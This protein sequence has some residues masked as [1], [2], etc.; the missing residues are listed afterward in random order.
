MAYTSVKISADSSSYQS[1]MKSAASQMKVLSAEYT[2]AA[3]KAKLFGSETDSL[4]AK[5]ESLTQKI[6]V[7]KNIVQL[8]SEQQEKL[9]KKLSDQKTKQEELKTKIDAAKEAYEKSTAET[10]KNSEQSKA[11]KD[12]LDKLEKEFTANETAIGKTETALANQTVKTEKSKTALMNMEAELKNVND[13]LKDNKLE[14]FATACD[15]AGTKMESFG[16][17][18]SVVSA[19][20]AGI[21]AASIKAFTELDEGYDTIVTKTGATGEA[22]E[23][24]TKSADNV[25]GTMPEDMS[26]VGE[27]I[28][29]VNTR[30]HTTGTELEKTS[31][32]FIQFAT[33]NGTNVTQSVDQ[34]DKIMKAWNVDASQTG[35]LL[36][37]LT[38]K[39]QETGISVDTLE[40]NVLDNN[41]AFKEMG[42][43]LPQAIN[44]MAQ[45][46][47]NGVDSTQAMAGLKKALQNAT[48]EGKSMDEALSETIG[49]IKNAK[50]ETEAMQIATELFGK[51]G[52]AEMTKAIRENRIDL[53][54]LS[55]SME[56]YGTTVEDTYNGTLD[57][58][59]NAKVAMNNAK[60]ALSTLASTAQTSAAPMIEKLTGKIQELTKWFTSLSPAQ[61]E[62]ILKV[63]LVVAAI[64]PLSIGFGKVAKGISDTVTTGQKFV[65][66]AAKI[67]AKITAKTAATAAGT[68]ADTAEFEYTSDYAGTMYYLVQDADQPEPSADA[69]LGGTKLA[70]GTDEAL[71]DLTGLNGNSAKKLYYITASSTAAGKDHTTAGKSGEMS[72]V[73]SANIPAYTAPSM[74]LTDTAAVRESKSTGTVTFTAPVAG[75]YHY[76]VRDVSELICDHTEVLAGTEAVMTVGENQIALTGLTDNAAKSVFLYAQGADGSNSAVTRI[77]LPAY[78][79]ATPSVTAP[80][81]NTLT[82]NGNAQPL[83]TAGSTSGGR[84]EYRLGNTG[85]YSADVPMATDAGIYTVWYKVVGDDTHDS[86]A[87]QSVSVTIEKATVTATAKSYEIYVNDK[88]PDLSAPAAGE[89][90]TVS[91]LA[92][93]DVLGG[94]AV[95]TYEKNGTAV[96]PDT[97]TAGI[98][99]IVLFG[100]TEPA[101]GN[102]E[103]L[104]LKNGT[105][106]VS[107]RPSSSGSSS[108]SH[109]TTYP[110]A[111]SPA[112]NGSVSLNTHGAAKGSTVTIT[113]KPDSGYKLDKLTVT[114]QNGNRLS[115]NDQGNGKYTF[116]MPAGKVSVEPVFTPIKAQPEFK[117]VAKDSYY[118][119]AVQWAVEKGITEGTSADT[120]SPGASCTRAQMVTFLWR[121]AGSPAPKSTTNPFKDI[122][123]TDYFYNAVLWAVENGITSGTGADTF[124]PATTVTRG[125][126]VTFLYRAAG[127][128]AV[129]GG[130]FSDVA[131]D[132]YYAKAVAWANENGITS[133]IGSNKFAP[134]ADCTRGQIVTLLY[135][136]Q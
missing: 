43:S 121:V 8:N 136:A 5:A 71:L 53:T 2:T 99:D 26:T 39:A 29:E 77:E 59:D 126:T 60:L 112:K 50:T 4:K 51:K 100:V 22:L 133:G 61:Q 46:D 101:G 65:S 24:L 82:Y 19:G 111:S 89:H 122:S 33:I 105:L 110:V 31:K 72:A 34:V 37:L 102:Y 55:S 123:S 92:E 107:A 18:M 94:T 32:Q 125:Q 14:K 106:T 44:L 109:T 15:T 114:D 28:G 7:Q 17:K 115:L 54:S 98:Y 134:N 117:D 118:Y 48:S 1:Q 21:G 41:A 58:I 127:S 135:R 116:T 64:G 16:K 79:P 57:P 73:K 113:V 74:V 36:G 56:E 49:S 96:T 30:F 131:A 67:I 40:S 130:S 23:G 93:T 103:P 3:T 87:E 66:G 25:F 42:L 9:T 128:P 47:A 97:S 12:E 81:A 129:S 76:I 35:N 11:L 38:A 52:A 95:L 68:A 90:Y 70:F 124:S 86:A 85:D 119:D 6:T 20:I 80:T 27:A 108:G 91:G 45:F 104:V 69:V 75:T 88:T 120:F 132:A 83:I 62:T 13:Q 78:H 84:M 63:G 10:G